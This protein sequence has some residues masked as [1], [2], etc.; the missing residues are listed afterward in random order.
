MSTKKIVFILLLMSST[1]LAYAQGGEWTW[2]KG[3]SNANVSGS[4]GIKGVSAPSN[5]PP[6]RY[7]AA[8]WKDLD[9]NFWVF[10]GHSDFTVPRTFYNDLWKFTVSTNEWTWVNGPQNNMNQAGNYGTLGVPSPLNLPPGRSYGSLCWVDSAGYLYLYGGVYQ[11]DLYSDLWRYNITTNEWTWIAG[12]NTPNA[13]P[14]YGTKG[15]SSPTNQPG[16]RIES[17]SNWVVNSKLFFFGG[18]SYDNS[19]NLVLRNDLWSFD[20]NSNEWTWEAG[21]N[22]ANQPA[23]YGTI[24][25]PSAS[26]EPGGS[27]SNANWKVKDSLFIFG[28]YTFAQGS[29]NTVWKY[30]LQS[31]LWTWINGS[32]SANPME[33]I[34]GLCISSTSNIP[35]GRYENRTINLQNNCKTALLTFGGTS[36]NNDLWLFDNSN[37]SW[38]LIWGATNG[39]PLAANYGTKGIAAASNSIPGRSGHCM[40]DDDQGNIWV[41]GG[42]SSNPINASNDL[43][44]FTPDTSC[45]N[46]NIVDSKIDFK[47]NDT[48]ICENEFINISFPKDA[49]IQINPFINVLY[50]SVNHSATFSPNSKQ[51]YTIRLTNKD[52]NP[53]PFDTSLSFTIDII[54]PNIIGLNDTSICLGST[55]K[56][57]FMP[58]ADIQIT[59]AGTSTYDQNNHSATFSPTSTQTYSVNLKSNALAQCPFDTTVS[60]T[61]NILQQP[62]SDFEAN[63][64]C[65][66]AA[67]LVVKNKS[68]EAENYQW[69]INGKQYSVDP[70]PSPKNI[71]EFDNQEIC[72]SL[73]ASNSCFSDSATFCIPSETQFK[74]PNAFSPNGD[75]HN[76]I[77]KIIRIGNGELDI[78]YLSVYNR[79][80]QRVFHT[81]HWQE[82]WD[83]SYKGDYA[84][85]GTYVFIIKVKEGSCTK[86][87]KGDVTL[88][89]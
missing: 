73:K 60:F 47:I 40:W 36:F 20:L 22:L 9:G 71:E 56:L 35:S 65:D 83:G 43:W 14:V 85:L 79:W 29:Y 59:P 82:G 44:K 72:V 87:V 4:Y 28:Q 10:G 19:N 86:E 37:R 16:P 54:K 58:E 13:S 11:G 41:F 78:Q 7:Q 55:Y 46:I 27:F 3:S 53:C 49:N 33:S 18:Q 75:G 63:L 57:N 38:K 24:N 69:Y 26:N 21:S 42:I 8:Y 61:V 52:N 12:N 67:L 88:I 81:T 50:D 74:I 25:V 89:R 31:K 62:T 68:S 66:D 39:L 2:M 30:D 17:N 76:D 64:N 5:N 48:S 1:T 70:Q 15:I 84:E 45:L 77:F 23:T 32:N 80:G 6:G 34:N 51:T